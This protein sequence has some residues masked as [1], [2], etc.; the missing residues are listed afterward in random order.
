MKTQSYDLTR[1]EHQLVSHILK[2][3]QEKLK[4]V[5]KGFTSKPFFFM[6]QHYT[7][8]LDVILYKLGGENHDNKNI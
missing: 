1:A 8:L 3:V 4:P 6:T 5:K 2:Q 7:E